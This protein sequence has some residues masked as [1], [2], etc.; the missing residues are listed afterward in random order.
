MTTPLTLV[1]GRRPDGTHHLAVSGE[2]DMSNIDSLAD[3]LSTTPGPLVLDLTD[4]EYL[5]S[6]GLSV[7]F[8][9]ADRL[10]LIATPLLAPVLRVSG[11]S[12]LTTVHGLD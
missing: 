12:D 3:A 9:H 6:A 5:D 7:L 4:V 10:E 11:L 8:A 1:P 2:I